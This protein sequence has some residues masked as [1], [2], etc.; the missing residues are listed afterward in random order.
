[1]DHIEL[2]QK[3][4]NLWAAEMIAMPVRATILYP[5]CHIKEI[6]QLIMNSDS[7]KPKK[8]VVNKEA[9]SSFTP[10]INVV[11]NFP[12]SSERL[13]YPDT[14]IV[15]RKPEKGVFN[16][17][18][19]NVDPSDYKDKGLREFLTWCGNEFKETELFE[20]EVYAKLR[21]QD[22]GLDIFKDDGG[23]DAETLKRECGLTF[24]TAKRLVT[25]YSRW[26]RSKKKVIATYS[27]I[28]HVLN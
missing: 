2:D 1:M 12:S 22:V 5:P 8:L 9:S 25:A 6:S 7:K 13:A 28:L 19:F 21:K 26:E 23:V 16:S 4:L 17:P 11:C 15:R 3:I 24:G 27:G 14:P 20:V 10:P 18:V